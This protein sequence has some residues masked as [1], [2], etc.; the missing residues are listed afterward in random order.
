MSYQEVILGKVVG[1]NG[2]Q[3][4]RGPRGVGINQIVDLGNN[5]IK[6]IYDDEREIEMTLETTTGP[7]GPKGDRGQIGPKGPKGEKGDGIKGVDKV[8]D[9][10]IRLR[11]GDNEYTD[12]NLNVVEGPR[13]PQGDRGPQGETGKSALDLWRDSLGEGNEAKTLSDLLK[14]LKGERGERG[15]IGETGPRGE[16]GPMGQRGERGERG[17]QGLRGNDGKSVTAITKD[18][19]NNV[20]F[21]MTDGSDVV[22][23]FPIEAG[24]DG[25]RGPAGPAGPTGERGADGHSPTL[26]VSEDGRLIVDG[27][28]QGTSLKGP[29]GERG[30]KGDGVSNIRQVGEEI[31]F[32]VGSREMKI[33]VPQVTAPESKFVDV[34]MSASTTKSRIFEGEKSKVVFTIANSGSIPAPRVEIDLSN[35]FPSSQGI[36]IE[37]AQID[38]VKAEVETVTANKSYVITNLESGGSVI[39]SM[40]V[41]FP[42][43]GSFTFSGNATVRGEVMDKSANDNRASVTV[44]VGSHKDTSYVPTQSCPALRVTDVDTGKQLSL[45][46]YSKAVNVTNADSYVRSMEASTDRLNVYSPETTQIKLN[47]PNAGTVQL[48]GWRIVSEGNAPYGGKAEYNKDIHRGVAYIYHGRKYLLDA[49]LKIFLSDDGVYHRMQ[50]MLGVTTNK[51]GTKYTA[52]SGVTF[53]KEGDVLTINGLQQGTWVNV[54]MRPAGENC[55]F[56]T[57]S[58]VVPYLIPVGDGDNSTLSKISGNDAYISISESGEIVDDKKDFVSVNSPLNTNMDIVKSDSPAS[59]KLNINAPSGTE[60]RFEFQVNGGKLNVEN[61]TVGNVEITPTN[62][63]TR[64]QIVIKNTATSADNLVYTNNGTTVDIKV[65]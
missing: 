15:P 41:T 14:T 56:Q 6:I 63:G 13:G 35:S 37:Q 46:N 23:K 54:N 21:R 43:V 20:H 39:I 3:G 33:P 38:K 4:P 50:P 57:V 26:T 53:V 36:Q 49:S 12:V 30:E 64:L 8:G 47:M 31:V 51:R 1:D 48:S 22:L 45:V 17:E 28:P 19:G 32:T 52:P 24:R 9:N 40:V 60:N 61:K 34:R 55:E 42:K 2:L 27:Q 11:Y 16:R 62:G 7:M 29:A 18:E 5:R 10:T 58:I 25:E 65:S 44:D 59:S